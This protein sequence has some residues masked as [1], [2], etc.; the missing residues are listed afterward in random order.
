VVRKF[1]YRGEDKALFVLFTRVIHKVFI[2]DD[3]FFRTWLVEAPLTLLLFLPEKSAV[4][5]TGDSWTDCN[6]SLTVS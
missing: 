3:D 4:Y 2:V 1:V 5:S 6:I